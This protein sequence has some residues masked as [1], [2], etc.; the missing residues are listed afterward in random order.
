MF[1]GNHLFFLHAL[2]HLA[3]AVI[4]RFNSNPS[5][6]SIDFRNRIT[7]SGLYMV[8]DFDSLPL[9]PFDPLYYKT[10]D[11]GVK[12]S[13]VSAGSVTVS[14]SCCSGGS[15]TAPV[16]TGEGV[17]NGSPAISAGAAAFTMTITF[18]QP[19]FAAGFGIADLYNPNGVNQAPIQVFD[20]PDGTGN[21]LDSTPLDNYCFQMNYVYFIGS[22]KFYRINIIYH[23]FIYYDLRLIVYLKKLIV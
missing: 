22:V 21:L 17:A 3:F 10:Y 13:F 6:N 23:L 18:G 16:S 4:Q 7:S 12:F 20:G 8:I 9:G 5:S 14:P 1:S 11:I 15:I 19:V 2:F